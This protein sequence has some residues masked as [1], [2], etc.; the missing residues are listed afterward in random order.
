MYPSRSSDNFWNVGCGPTSVAIIL[1]AYGVTGGVGKEALP[2]VMG[3]RVGVTTDGMG[4]FDGA[5]QVFNEMGISSK[6]YSGGPSVIYNAMDEALSEGRPVI[7]NVASW[8]LLSW[9]T[10]Y[11]C[12]R[13]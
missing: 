12:F 2:Y 5:T 11:S 1:S 10:L 6:T 7:V 4:S 8:K 13:I 3:E 9:R